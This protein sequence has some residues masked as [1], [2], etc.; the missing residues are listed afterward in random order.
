MTYNPTFSVTVAPAS[1]SAMR[2]TTTTFAVTINR[3]Q[4]VP[5]VTLSLANQMPSGTTYSFSPNPVTGV[6]VDAH[7][8]DLEHAHGHPAGGRRAR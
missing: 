8:H 4:F 6:D 3:N 2:G 5:P 1:Q 7:D